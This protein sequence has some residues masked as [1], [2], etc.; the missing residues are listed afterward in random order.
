MRAPGDDTGAGSVLAIAIMSALLIV[1]S[2]MVPVGALLL[3]D[4]RAS[5]AADAAAL[6]AADGAVGLVAG[7]PCDL[8][9]TVAA[10]NGAAVQRCEVDGLVVTVRTT[11]PVLGFSIAGRATACPPPAPP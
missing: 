7:S 3:A 8:A 2:T 1:T 11:V 4:R 10:A 9:R 6:A 5:G